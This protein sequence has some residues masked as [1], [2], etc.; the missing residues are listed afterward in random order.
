[1]A[2][3][4]EG[5]D[6]SFHKQDDDWIVDVSY[7]VT[8][9]DDPNYRKGSGLRYGTPAGTDTVDT[10]RTNIENMIKAEEGIT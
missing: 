1:M 6:F 3:Q 4:I 7:M 5:F 10:I 9:P 8:D 2:K